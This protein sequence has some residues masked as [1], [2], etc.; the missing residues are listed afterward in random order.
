MKILLYVNC[1]RDDTVVLFP[2]RVY[3]KLPHITSSSSFSY[4]HVSCIHLSVLLCRD[5][6]QF[7]VVLHKLRQIL[8][9]D[10]TILSDTSRT[11]PIAAAAALRAMT[12]EVSNLTSGLSKVLRTRQAD[13]ETSVNPSGLKGNKQDPVQTTRKEFERRR[14]RGS[15]S[16]TVNAASA[17][18]LW[19]SML[20]D[21]LETDA[22]V[23]SFV[24]LSLF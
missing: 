3:C 4:M 16:V 20:K 15:D 2:E 13:M 10:I 17:R 22:A 7:Y 5:L 1:F 11:T 19:D 23:N 8:P 12:S 18:R 21:Q 14:A 6:S 9:D 24:N